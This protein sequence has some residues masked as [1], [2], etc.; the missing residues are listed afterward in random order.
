MPSYRVAIGVLDVRAGV[1]PPDLLP[2][3]EELLARHHL[4]EDRSV[5]VVGG[6]AELH[7][8]F[9]VPTGDDRAQDDAAEAAVRSVVDQLGELADLSTWSL[10][11]G[12]GRRWR[13]VRTGRA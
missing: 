8:R 11:R 6:R 3:A 13:T 5:E 7:L 1:D 12:P 10:R 2:R 4:V 9:L